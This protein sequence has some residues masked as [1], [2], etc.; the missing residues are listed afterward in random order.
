MHLLSR[1]SELN[2]IQKTG[3]REYPTLRGTKL[4]FKRQ[5]GHSTVI[6]LL[7]AFCQKPPIKHGCL[8][9]TVI[10]PIIKM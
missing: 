5:V 1:I 9:A 3:G 4:E 6:K 7:I 10:T 2:I 8:R